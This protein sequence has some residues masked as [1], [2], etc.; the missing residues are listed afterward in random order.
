MT[1]DWQAGLVFFFLVVVL[2]KIGKFLLFKVPALAE[3][4]AENRAE[5]K[6]KLK[7][8]KYRPVIKSGQRVGLVANLLFL[9]EHVAPILPVLQARREACD[10]M[11]GVVA[12]AA[13]VKLTSHSPVPRRGDSLGRDISSEEYP[14]G[15]SSVQAGS[16]TTEGATIPL[17][18][19]GSGAGDGGAA[20]CPRSEAIVSFESVSMGSG[21]E[22]DRTRSRRARASAMRSYIVPRRSLARATGR[23]PRFL[24]V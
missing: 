10:A 7:K 9:E 1:Y 12:D 17:F 24:S 22:P 5:D 6:L 13:I 2:T 15:S 14:S 23:F 20:S 21:G 16:S 19:D 8:D 11:I 18:V 4:K 3:C